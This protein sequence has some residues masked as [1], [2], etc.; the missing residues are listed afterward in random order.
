[1]NFGLYVYW[2]AG[3]IYVGFGLASV[4]NECP[5]NTRAPIDIVALVAVWPA[6]LAYSM[7]VKD[8]P[9]VCEKSK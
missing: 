4:H 5:G 3:C 8:E 7:K 6:A 1:M 9:Y 2:V